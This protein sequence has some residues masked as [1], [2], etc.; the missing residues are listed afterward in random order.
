MDAPIAY[1]APGPTDREPLRLFWRERFVAS[2]GH[3]YPPE[4]LAAFLAESYTPERHRL[5]DP[6]LA[7]QIAVAGGMI[8]GAVGNG[9]L[10]LPIDPPDGERAWELRRLYLADQ[11][12]GAGVA[13]QLMAWSKAEA[14]G[15]GASAL[16]LGVWS[17]NVR[18]HR[19]YARHG[20]ARVGGYKFRVGDTLDDE[21][22]MRASLARVA[23][24][25]P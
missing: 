4:D 16:Y 10:H 15:R 1:R 17:E 9:P 3:T 5:D 14:R 21:W 20:F 8:V 19:F 2:F 25:E 11:V 24:G 23:G 12:K 7:Y 13:D 6:E 18:A 22:I